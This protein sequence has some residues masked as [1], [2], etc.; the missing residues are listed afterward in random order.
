MKTVTISYDSAASELMV[1]PDPVPCSVSKD[2][3][4]CWETENL[5]DWRVIFAADAPVHPK[6]A[7]PGSESNTLLLKGNRPED[8]RHVKYTVVAMTPDGLKHL[9]PEMIVD[10]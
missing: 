5:S 8:Y 4:V 7:S 1:N 2:R 10:S 9:D 3:T 6:V